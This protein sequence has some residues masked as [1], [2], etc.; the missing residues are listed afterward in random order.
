MTVP[1][2]RIPNQEA[3]MMLL[4]N[5]SRFLFCAAVL[6]LS[7]GMVSCNETRPD[8]RTELVGSLKGA[9]LEGFYFETRDDDAQEI[10]A[11]TNGIITEPIRLDSDTTVVLRY[12]RVRDKKA[13]TSTLYKTEAIRAGDQL[14]FQVTDVASGASLIKQTSDFLAPPPPALG[15]A[16]SPAFK[17]LGDC[18]CSLRASLLFEANRTCTPQGAAVICCIDGTQLISAHLLVMPTN[19]ICQVGV[20]TGFDDL[21]FFRD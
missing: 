15:A 7:L 16:C 6:C 1:A 14:T 13:N 11:L 10:A 8:P 9:S 12:T 4:H 17:S 19:L 18:T 5:P 20:L 21:L 2:T 3:M